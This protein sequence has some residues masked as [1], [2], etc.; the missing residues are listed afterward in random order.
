M[1]GLHQG[2]TL[3]F[4]FLCLIGWAVARVG[5]A[6]AIRVRD[7]EPSLEYKRVHNHLDTWKAYSR[8]KHTAAE[9]CLKPKTTSEP[10]FLIRPIRRVKASEMTVEEFNSK[11]VHA[12]RALPIIF[13]DDNFDDSEWTPSSFIEQCGD[14]PIEDS[15]D[16]ELGE[17][18]SVREVYESLVGEKWAGLGV[19]DLD[20]HNIVTMEDLLNAQGTP[21]GKG[22]YLHDA[23]LSWH[24]PPKVD[25]IKVPKYFPRNYDALLWQP[26]DLGKTAVE[27]EF[28]WPSIF[29]SKAGTGSRLHSD[30]RMTRFYTQ[31]LHGAKLWR[32]TP[33]SEYWRLDPQSNPETT[34]YPTIFGADIIEPDFEKHEHLDGT[35]VYETIMK[36]GDVL[37]LPHGWPHQVLNVKESVMSAVNYYDSTVLDVAKQCL[38]F[39]E[40]ETND[41]YVIKAFFMP[42]DDPVFNDG[43][44]EQDISWS[45]FLRGQHLQV[46]EVPKWLIEK[47]KKEPHWM[48]NYRDLDGFPALHVAVEY[49][50]MKLVAFLIETAGVNVNFIDRLGSTA[51]D[52]VRDMN[53]PEMEKLLLNHGALSAEQIRYKKAANQEPQAKSPSSSWW[54]F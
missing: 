10:S 7:D 50:F 49:N 16:E 17:I 30:S 24:C 19:P 54:P 1:N 2:F 42:L 9:M 15:E 37:F 28:Q 33:P 6:S 36:K 51:L 32:V 48:I 14:I 26:K 45:D 13:E 52:L 43:D 3:Q 21:E 4:L 22:L 25:K 5:A 44:P 41:L 8:K 20:K 27:L 39:E 53:Y 40:Y 35:L 18:H 46:A 23:P 38:E 34:F 47:V 11:F 29:I 31:V 12:D